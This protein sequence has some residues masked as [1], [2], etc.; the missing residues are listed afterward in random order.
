MWTYRHDQ[1]NAYNRKE[2]EQ[3]YEDSFRDIFY[4]YLLLQYYIFPKLNGDP[5]FGVSTNNCYL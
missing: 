1:T 4:W 3:L 5:Q 2:A